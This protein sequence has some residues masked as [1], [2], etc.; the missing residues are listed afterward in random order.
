MKN[1]AFALAI[2][3]RRNVTTLPACDIATS[4]GIARK[5]ALSCVN[6][7]IAPRA[8]T[9][10]ASSSDE[11]RLCLQFRIRTGTAEHKPEAQYDRA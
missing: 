7:T 1:T 6:G 2:L 10:A 11:R 5:L 4:S 3:V 9:P 8:S